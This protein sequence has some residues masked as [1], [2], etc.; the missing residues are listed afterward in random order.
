[1]GLEQDGCKIDYGTACAVC[2]RVIGASDAWTYLVTDYNEIL[3][4]HQV[5]IPGSSEN[6]ELTNQ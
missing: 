3:P 4:I 6:W 5:C 2:E 1:M